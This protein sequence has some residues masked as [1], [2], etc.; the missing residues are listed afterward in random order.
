M[1]AVIA[2]DP[3]G[4]VG[5]LEDHIGTV[6]DLLRALMM[7]AETLDD[8]RSAVWR[9]AFIAQ[10]EMQAIGEIHGRLFRLLHPNRDHFE[11]EGW[12]CDG[13]VQ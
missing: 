6:D 1:S 2:S 10:K 4:L 13:G 8:D 7:L 5:D 3:F 12:P 9:V 11:V